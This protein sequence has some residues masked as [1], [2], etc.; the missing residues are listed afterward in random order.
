MDMLEATSVG[1]V[2]GGDTDGEEQAEET[3]TI[4]TRVGDQAKLATQMNN[5]TMAHRSMP[6]E[7]RERRKKGDQTGN[8]PG[9]AEKRK[10]GRN[11]MATWNT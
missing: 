2:K 7:K 3:G 1:P 8:K 10:H 5:G 4:A 6:P 9:K 11:K